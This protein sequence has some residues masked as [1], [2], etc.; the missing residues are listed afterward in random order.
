MTRKTVKS[1]MIAPD[2]LRTGAFVT[3]HSSRTAEQ[4]ATSDFEMTMRGESVRS[5]PTPPMGMPLKVLSVNLPYVLVTPV[6]PGDKTTKLTTVDLRHVN[7]MRVSKAFVNA[8]L[9]FRPSPPPKREPSEEG[10]AG[11]TEVIESIF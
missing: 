6:N 1:G 7:L 3:I 11:G 2:D 4:P 9:R 5:M 8:V 10:A